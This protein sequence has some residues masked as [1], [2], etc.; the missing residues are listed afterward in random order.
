MKVFEFPERLIGEEINDNIGFDFC[1]DDITSSDIILCNGYG[2][3]CVLIEYIKP[4]IS[5][6]WTIITRNANSLHGVFWLMGKI[7]YIK[8]DATLLVH[9]ARHSF[10]NQVA[11][12]LGAHEI[13]DFTRKILKFNDEQRE[14]YWDGEDLIY[15]GE[16]LIK[17]GIAED[18]E[19]ANICL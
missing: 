9:A 19:N 2:G 17:H 16:E 10:N 14:R 4:I 15:L 13:Y 6:K 18:L 1:I 8:K 12:T 11:V 3:N 5:N 7:R